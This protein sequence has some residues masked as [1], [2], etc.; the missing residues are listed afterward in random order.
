MMMEGDSF[1]W[2]ERGL[3]LGLAPCSSSSQTAVESERDKLS[4]VAELM[5]GLGSRM[6]S[7]S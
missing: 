7:V 5:I 4:E 2:T 3:E 1:K 6:K